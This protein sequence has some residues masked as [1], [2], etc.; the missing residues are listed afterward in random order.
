MDMQYIPFDEQMRSRQNDHYGGNSSQMIGK[1]KYYSYRMSLEPQNRIYQNVE[2]H[3]LDEKYKIGEIQ[4]QMEIC[5]IIRYEK[6][7]RIDE[8]L[9]DSIFRQDYHNYQVVIG[10]SQ[11]FTLS[12]RNEQLIEKY[13]QK[14]RKIGYKSTTKIQQIH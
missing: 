12:E 8:K 5:L 2:Y 1:M 10:Y 7:D 13:S 14:V 4:V 6:E 3:Y 9:L 11:N